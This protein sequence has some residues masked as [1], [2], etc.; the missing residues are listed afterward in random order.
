M[1]GSNCAHKQSIIFVGPFFTGRNNAM[2]V[3]QNIYEHINIVV[4][5]PDVTSRLVVGWKSKFHNGMKSKFKLTIQQT[6]ISH[7]QGQNNF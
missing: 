5:H 4:Y 2:E 1:Y 3:L 7:S 6:R